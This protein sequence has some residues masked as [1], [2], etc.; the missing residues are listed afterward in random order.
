MKYNLY[1][2]AHSG[3]FNILCLEE[4]NLPI[5]LNAYKRGSDSFTL[6]GVKHIIN[7]LSVLKIFSYDLAMSREDF[8]RYCHKNNQLTI[9]DFEK[10]LRPSVLGIYGK[11]LTAQ[12]IGNTEFGEYKTN[13]PENLSPFIDSNRL[14]QI[15]EIENSSF[16][17]SILIELCNEI[18]DNFNR[19][20]YFSVAMLCRSL[21]DHIPPIFNQK[22]F[23]EVANNFGS[24]SFKDCMQH[25]DNSMRKIADLYL[26]TVISTKNLQ[27]N[28]TQVNFS[29]EIDLLLSEVIKICS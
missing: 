27:P 25:L 14:L 23:K 26:H 16:D 6:L 5:I 2:K 8:L 7:G 3:T 17:F 29:Q 24:K 11:D 21:I 9:N 28:R 22:T 4:D 12:M 1:F 15:K 10:Y 19:E 18:N 13:T 20:N